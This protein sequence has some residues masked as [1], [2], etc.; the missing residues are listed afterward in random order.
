MTAYLIVTQHALMT[1]TESTV[2]TFAHVRMEPSAMTYQEN[3]SVLPAG[4]VTTVLSLA[5][6]VGKSSI[7]VPLPVSFHVFV[8]AD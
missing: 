1:D 4:L 6:M 8:F 7:H 3:V 5:L 2:T